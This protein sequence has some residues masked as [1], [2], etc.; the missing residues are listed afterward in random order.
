[1]LRRVCEETGGTYTIARDRR[2]VAARRSPTPVFSGGDAI[3]VKGGAGV[4]NPVRARSTVVRSAHLRELLRA[5]IEPPRAT[6]R[7]GDTANGGCAVSGVAL[8]VSVVAL[9]I[10]LPVATLGYVFSPSSRRRRVVVRT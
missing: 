3:I 1:M 9:A 7:G 6:A 10:A 8:P 5:H 4:N 2:V